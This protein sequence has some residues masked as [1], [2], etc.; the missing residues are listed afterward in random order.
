LAESLDGGNAGVR[1]AP[2]D[3]ERLDVNH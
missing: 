1:V 2:N 3:L